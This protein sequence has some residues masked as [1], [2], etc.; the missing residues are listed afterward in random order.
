MML[1]VDSDSPYRLCVL[2]PTHNHHRALPEIVET[3]NRHNLPVFIVDDG[4][5]Q[6]TQ[7]ALKSLCQHFPAIQMLRLEKNQGKGA[8]IRVGMK[9][10]DEQGFT[11]AFQIDADGQHDLTTLNDFLTLSKNNPQGLISGHPLYDQSIPLGRKIGRWFTHIWAWIETLSLSITDSMCGFRIYPVKQS[12]FIFNSQKIGTH[13]DFDTQI[14]VHL[15][16]AG[17]PVLMHPVRVTYP[18][19][20][21]SNFRVWSDNWLITKMHTKLF[22]GMLK[23]LPSLLRRRRLVKPLTWSRLEEQGSYFGLRFLGHCYRL[24]GRH[25]CRIVGIPLVLYFYLKGREQRQASRD[26]LK[27]VHHLSHSS[28]KPGFRESFRH[29]MSFF[30][31]A[32]DKF[33]AWTGTLNL[34]TLSSQDQEKFEALMSAPTGGMLLVSHLGNMEFCRAAARSDHKKRLHILLHSKN[35]Q[36]FQRFLKSFNPNSMLN[37]I[38]VTELGP[39]TILYLKE[40]LSYGEWVVIAGDRVPVTGDQRLCYAQ[41]FG[42]LAPFSQGPYILASLLECPVYTAFALR[43]KN[44]FHLSVDLFSEK[45][46]LSRQTRNKDLQDYAQRYATILEDKAKQYPYQWFNFFDFW[47]QGK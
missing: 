40:R 47:K 2:I 35:A 18:Q 36:R 14:M 6:E 24:L 17:T 31:M 13:M 26:F 27:R 34:S 28:K 11:H 41:F 29:F 30:E 23:N 3:L 8:A 44:Q 33:S 10:V 9:W 42:E 43:E 25:F 45:I 39:H 20:N 5:Q 4:S 1:T 22:F 12:V 32:L 16:W 38:E 37:I 46:T 21:L 7:L 15:F 19:G